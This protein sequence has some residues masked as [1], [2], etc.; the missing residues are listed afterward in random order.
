MPSPASPQ[1]RFL[2]RASALLLLMLTLWWWLLLTPLL[3]AMRLSSA[4]VLRLLPGGSAS[5]GITVAPNTD[6]I[7]QV[8]IPA[9]IATQDAVQRA[10]GRPPGAPPVKVRSFKI[11]IARQIP[12]FFTLSF[13]LFW[14]L[15]L[16]APRGPHFWR[17]LATGTLLLSALAMVSLLVYTAYSIGTNIH[18]IAAGPAATLCAAV[19]YLNVNVVPYVA[20]L[21]L[22]LWLYAELRSQIFFADPPIRAAHVSKR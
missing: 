13:P 8:P 7:L 11:A 17:S 22:A 4:V 3:A 9:S 5:S 18:L 10:F 6:W 20:P 1:F 19:E 15:A 16:A 2:L 12:I 14:A 21:M